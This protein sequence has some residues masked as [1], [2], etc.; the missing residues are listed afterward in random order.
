MPQSANH[1]KAM[2][3]NRLGTTL[4]HSLDYR[5]TALKTSLKST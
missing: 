4:T 2:L 3:S 5:I 1:G